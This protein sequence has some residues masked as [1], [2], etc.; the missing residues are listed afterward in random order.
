MGAINAETLGHTLTHEHLSLDF[1]NFYR[2]PPAHLNTYLNTAEIKLGNVGF[3]KQYPYGSLY[4]LDFH[5]T[6]DQ[7]THTN[8]L[9]DVTLYKQWGGGSIVENSSHGLKRNLP[10]LYEVAQKTGVNIIAGTGHYVKEVQDEAALKLSIEQMV[11]LYRKD[12]VD[13]YDLSGDGKTIIKCGI[14]G[15]VG[16]V[17]PIQGF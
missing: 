4:N 13:G 1:S 11:E 7:L 10:F 16:S 5:T 12:M 15:E 2:A 9:Q 3:L 6:E 17:W 8:I 14:V